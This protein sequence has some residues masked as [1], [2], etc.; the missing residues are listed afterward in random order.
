MRTWIAQNAANEILFLTLL[1]IGWQGYEQY[2]Q[3]AL[4]QRTASFSILQ[5]LQQ[6]TVAIEN[7]IY[8]GSTTFQKAQLDDCHTLG[9]IPIKD[10]LTVKHII[11]HYEMYYDAAKLPLISG[12]AW[13]SICLGGQDFIKSNCLL[14]HEWERQ[15]SKITS[16]EFRASFDKCQLIR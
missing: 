13:R 5:Q 2:Q 16:P 9:D 11:G 10:S 15:Y 12:D 4:T 7:S 8:E 6:Q 14:Q 1:A 3:T